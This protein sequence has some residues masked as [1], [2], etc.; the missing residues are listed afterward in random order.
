MTEEENEPTS[1]KDVVSV[2]NDN[3]D[4]TN[5]IKESIQT[6][7]NP[8][9]SE[10]KGDSLCDDCD[11]ALVVLKELIEKKKDNTKK[12]K[13]K[14]KWDFRTSPHEQFG[15]TLDDTFISF[16]LWARTN[17]D[18]SDTNDGKRKI[19]V[20]KAFRRVESYADWME[21]TKDDLIEPP[22]T[23]KSVQP[24]LDAL[25]M[26]V[27]VDNQGRFVWW[28]D[29]SVIDV[30]KIKKELPPEE[31]LRA[32]VW[33]AHYVM[34]DENA[35]ENGLVFVENLNY[36]G[37]IRMMTMIPM[38]LSTK[39][40][41]LTIGVLPVKMNALYMLE[42]PRWVNM[43]MRFMGMFMSKKMKER[44]VSLKEWD[45]L[46]ETLGKE[47]IPKGFGKLEGSL[48]VDP[49]KEKYFM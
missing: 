46:E 24:A 5:V 10:K 45:K 23:S 21:E 8:D 13:K 35:Q 20:S 2:M 27:S 7:S 36:M 31:S 29:L 11:S 16:L 6:F 48:E 37:M 49:V 12:E 39:L 18:D 43:F 47:C 41:R 28:I 38:K 25:S 44:I 40:D 19:N 15:K 3:S 42:T 30:E 22:L 1:M 33:F 9:G 17:P 32:F 4:G 34:Y 26:R 14:A